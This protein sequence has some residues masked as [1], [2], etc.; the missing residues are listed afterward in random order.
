M[1]KFEDRKLLLAHTRKRTE[2]TNGYAH[3]CFL[4]K[5]LVLAHHIDVCDW[6]K[7]KDCKVIEI[8]FPL[9][10]V[11]KIYDLEFSKLQQLQNALHN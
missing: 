10:G 1:L 4:H 2:V 6:I 8:L 5:N 9:E 11:A 7:M 3:Y